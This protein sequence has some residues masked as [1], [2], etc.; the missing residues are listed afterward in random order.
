[1]KWT[2][3]GVHDDRLW[4]E[5]DHNDLVAYLLRQVRAGRDEKRYTPSRNLVQPEM[6]ERVVHSDA[7][8]AVPRGAKLI[9]RDEMGYGAPQYIR[10]VLPGWEEGGG[11]PEG[12]R[13]DGRAGT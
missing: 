7:E 5:P 9:C 6:R 10:Y 2:A 12:A 3:G 4:D 8:L 11:T 1:M 13:A